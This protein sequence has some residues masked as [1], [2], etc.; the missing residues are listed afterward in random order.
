MLA[1]HG[2]AVPG[3]GSMQ[4]RGPQHAPLQDPFLAG[5]HTYL[6]GH[7]YNTSRAADLWASVGGAQSLLGMG[8][9]GNGFSAQPPCQE[10]STRVAL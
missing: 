5:L 6:Q 2:T 9:E 7:A 8:W 4:L 1:E 3:P 10:H